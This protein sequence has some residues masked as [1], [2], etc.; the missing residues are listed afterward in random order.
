MV[1]RI[2]AL[3]LLALSLGC[4]SGSNEQGSITLLLKDAPGD[5]IR[6][7][8]VTIAGVQ[9]RTPD[10]RVRVLRSTPLTVDLMSLTERPATLVDGIAIPAGTYD[11]LRLLLD[12]AFLEVAGESGERWLFATEGYA[13]VPEGRPADG[14]L[15]VAQAETAGY[16]VKLPN[17]GFEIDPVD[18]RTTLIVDFDVAESFQHD[19]AGTADW[20]MRPSLIAFERASAAEIDVTV[21]PTDDRSAEVLGL[22]AVQ[23]M[24]ASGQLEGER[25]LTDEDGDHTFTAHFGLVNPEEGPFG[26]VLVG[27]ADLAFRV[28]PDDAPVSLVA[29]GHGAAS[30]TVE[31][32][33]TNA[34]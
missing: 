27:P 18:E 10:G 19:L 34:E 5:D 24:D 28:G 8:M 20:V 15:Q 23:L 13:A 9:A 11:E 30:R 33:D 16:A 29:G 31:I 3:G 12:G 17:G 2:A 22:F 7:A 4:G 26:T 1:P 32:V 25:R 21:K 6:A 14:G